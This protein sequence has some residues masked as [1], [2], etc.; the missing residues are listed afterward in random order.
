M[1]P[2]KNAERTRLQDYQDIM[3]KNKS[4]YHGRRPGLLIAV[5]PRYRYCSGATFSVAVA[6]AP[7]LLAESSADGSAATFF[8]CFLALFATATF[9][10]ENYFFPLLIF[11]RASSRQS[12]NFSRR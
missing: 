11:L 2:T 5:V 8:S 1:M 7:L 4:Y 10:K 3:T 9:L 6:V 12:S